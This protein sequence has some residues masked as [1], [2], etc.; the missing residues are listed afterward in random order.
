MQVR[1]LLELVSLAERVGIASTAGQTIQVI[2]SN[3]NASE[4]VLR[5]ACTLEPQAIDLRQS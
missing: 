5:E 4:K 3:L 2:S 1:S